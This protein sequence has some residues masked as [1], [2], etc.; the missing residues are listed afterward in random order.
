MLAKDLANIFYQNFFVGQ[1][2]VYAILFAAALYGI[3]RILISIHKHVSIFI[4]R[5]TFFPAFVLPIQNISH[6]A[7]ASPIWLGP[8]HVLLS[9]PGIFRLDAKGKCLFI[10]VIFTTL[11]P[12][13][14]HTS[15]GIE[16]ATG[17][18]R[19]ISFLVVIIPITATL[20]LLWILSSLE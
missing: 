4:A 19:E 1:Q 18:L 15:E 13:L 6:S 7:T 14:L 16:V 12:D 17:A 3:S 10:T 9:I 11:L 2:L 8:L 20:G 5:R